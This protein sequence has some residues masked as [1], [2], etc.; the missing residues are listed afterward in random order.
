MGGDYSWDEEYGSGAVLA[1][2]LGLGKPKPLMAKLNN[3]GGGQAIFEPVAK[4]GELYMWQ[5]EVGEIDRIVSP[6][7]LAEVKDLIATGK[8]STIKLEKVPRPTPE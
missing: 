1:A 8:I 3:Y 7:T 2:E 5:S 6:T 4:P